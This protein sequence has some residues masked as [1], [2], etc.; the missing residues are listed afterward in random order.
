MKGHADNLGY[1]N[2]VRFDINSVDAIMDW[3]VDSFCAITVELINED[4]DDDA[5]NENT[6]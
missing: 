5:N 1:I 2:K 3:I 6:G 4:D